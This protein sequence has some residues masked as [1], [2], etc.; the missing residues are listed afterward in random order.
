[1]DDLPDEIL[2][3]LGKV[4]FLAA[5]L[6]QAMS[7]V[8][9]QV[10][11]DELQLD[12]PFAIAANSRRAVQLAERAQRHPS[13][14]P[15]LQTHLTELIEYSK[16]LIEKRN[17][18]VHAA[19]MLDTDRTTILMHTLKNGTDIPADS[20]W[21]D[22]CIHWLNQWT[23]RWYAVLLELVGA[24]DEPAIPAADEELLTRVAPMAMHLIAHG[25]GE[26]AKPLLAEIAKVDG[27]APF[28]AA[29][30]QIAE[31]ERD[32]QRLLDGLGEESGL[33]LNVLDNIRN[34][35]GTT[36]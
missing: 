7:Y 9:A 21:L 23:Q 32:E 12:S 3:K 6:E 28:A 8:A 29:L 25:D 33:I 14:P 17:E 13:L 20:G 35:E 36:P 5:R 19:W 2:L 27:W 1:M 34:R 30:R 11:H 22:D 4:T 24:P 26:R 10:L 15:Q 18:I 31:G 16:V